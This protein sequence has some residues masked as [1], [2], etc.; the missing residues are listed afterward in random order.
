MICLGG[1]NL[2]ITPLFLTEQDSPKL[3]Y[4][5][6]MDETFEIMTNFYKHS[7]KLGRECQYIHNNTVDK[8]RGFQGRTC[9]TWV[10]NCN[11]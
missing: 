8:G 11:S 9:C 10:Q 2:T 3:W 4:P 5:K 6:K 1:Y 7:S